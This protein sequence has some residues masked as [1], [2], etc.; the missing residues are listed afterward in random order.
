M[1]HQR[2]N[3]AEMDRFNGLPTGNRVPTLLLAKNPGLS[4]T[5]MNNFPGPVWSMQMFKYKEKMAFP[6]NIQSVVH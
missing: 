4:R 2:E 3:V 1:T 5:P 6:Y